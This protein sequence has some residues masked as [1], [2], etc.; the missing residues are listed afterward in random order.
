MRSAFNFK[1]PMDNMFRALGGL[2]TRGSV[3]PPALLWG[4]RVQQHLPGLATTKAMPEGGS[5]TE[6]RDL[7]R[8]TTKAMPE[9]G[10]GTEVRD[11]GRATTTAFPEG[12]SGTEVRDLG[13]ATTMAFP[14]GGS[15]MEVRDPG[16]ATTMAFPEGGQQTDVLQPEKFLRDV[17]KEYGL[18]SEGGNFP[19]LR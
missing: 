8:A 4:G 14:E 10:S 19:S 1:L 12:G 6:V 5:G 3:I 7:G 2:N 17:I 18:E 16:V 11:L 13:R 15:G 9:G